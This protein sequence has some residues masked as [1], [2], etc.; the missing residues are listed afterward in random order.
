MRLLI[1]DLRRLHE[2]AE[3]V[4][5][6]ADVYSGMD[7]LVGWV[8]DQDAIQGCSAKITDPLAVHRI[9]MFVNKDHQ[10]R[11]LTSKHDRSRS[12]LDVVKLLEGNPLQK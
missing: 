11:K 2:V 7:T 5:T 3:Q 6:N 12:T 8:V 4:V 9:S 1:F 10:K